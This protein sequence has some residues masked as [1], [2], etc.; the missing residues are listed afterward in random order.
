M[1]LGQPLAV[2]HPMSLSLVAA[3]AGRLLPARDGEIIERVGTAARQGDDVRG[4]PGAVESE[5]PV[6]PDAPSGALRVDLLTT[7]RLMVG[8]GESGAATVILCAVRCL[9]LLG[10]PVSSLLDSP[11]LGAV[12]GGLPGSRLLG[13]VVGGPP[14]SA[15]L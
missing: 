9:A 15:F 12:I 2:E 7:P 6:A 10:A 1:D 8:A 11:L 5:R 14:G 4:F 13:A 3:S